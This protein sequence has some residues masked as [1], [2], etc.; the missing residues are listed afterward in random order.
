MRH[1]FTNRV[2]VVLI[3]AVLIAVG[4]GVIGSLTN[5]SV[6]D[7]FVQGVLTPIRTGVSKLT[8]G[9]EQVYNYIFEYE[10]LKA[11]NEDLKGQVSQLEDDARQV[12]AISRELERLRALL[13][14]KKA[15]EDYKIGRASCR[16]RV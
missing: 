16:E 15:N 10:A 5:L 14:L 12:D 4:L 8:D 6:G 13:E 2:R 11:E 7:M 3:L 1:F 9:A